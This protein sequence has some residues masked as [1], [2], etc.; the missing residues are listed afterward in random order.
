VFKTL[1]N[2]S[3]DKKNG[4]AE[5]MPDII[6]MC[7]SKT[8]LQELC[9]LFP[10]TAENIKR[11]SLER[12]LRFMIQKNTNSRRFQEKENQKKKNGDKSGASTESQQKPGDAINDDQQLE[13]FYS[14]EEPENFESQKED[15]KMY[16]NKLNKRIDLLVDALKEADAK[17]SQMGDQK[18]IMEQINMKKH[19]NKKG[20]SQD[21]KKDSIAEIFKEKISKKS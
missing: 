20:N 4:T 5:P 16:L 1:A 6:F 14:D 7:I 15:M 12:R 10:Q 17:M 8:E 21:K 11:R 13:D 19:K 9:D 3:E 18:A 2:T